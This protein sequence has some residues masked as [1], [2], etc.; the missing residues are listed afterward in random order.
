MGLSTG[1]RR[2]KHTPPP[3]LL[4]LPAFPPRSL[5]GKK[6][7]PVLIYFY[8]LV[9]WYF[10]ITSTGILYRGITT[11][12]QISGLSPRV[13]TGCFPAHLLTACS[14]R[15][16]PTGSART[17]PRPLPDSPLPGAAR[18][19][20]RCH[21]HPP[22]RG[23][24]LSPCLLLE[25]GGCS[26]VWLPSISTTHL[27]FS[28]SSARRGGTGLQPRG[29][30]APFSPHPLAFPLTS[31]V[32][33]SDPDGHLHLGV[34]HLSPP[35]RRAAPLSG[36]VQRQRPCRAGARQ[37][38]GGEGGGRGGGG[39]GGGGEG[40]GGRA[41]AQPQS[42]PRSAGS[43]AARRRRRLHNCRCRPA[44][45]SRHLPPQTRRGGAEQHRKNSSAFV[46]GERSYHASLQAATEEGCANGEK[47]EQRPAAAKEREERRMRREGRGSRALRLA[48]TLPSRHVTLRG[49]AVP[50]SP[51]PSAAVRRPQRPWCRRF[52]PW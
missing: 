16:S 18:G 34:R 29:G 24:Y 25:G 9:H 14:R 51:V 38:P 27:V 37:G 52:F 45:P 48:L 50:P 8:S 26:T 42:P 33:G 5:K 32:H 47:A 23:V 41:A 49:G 30:R 40:G 2:D 15:T 35:L 11:T 19:R 28:S 17:P 39:E 21:P 36:T 46:H 1:N 3:L 22:R 4:H 7:F 10:W 13:L 43:G 20:A 12:R 6:S 44:N 31:P